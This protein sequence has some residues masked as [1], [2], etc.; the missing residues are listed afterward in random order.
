M[1]IS[2][3]VAAGYQASGAAVLD[4]AVPLGFLNKL[5]SWWALDGD[6]LDAWGPFPL[7]QVSS[8]TGAFTLASTHGSG[9]SG[10]SLKGSYCK[11][12]DAWP[13]WG[14]AANPTSFAIGAFR[15]AD[16][17]GAGNQD[18]V[19]MKAGFNESV[20]LQQFSAGL[21]GRA[22]SDAFG[23]GMYGV[24]ANEST[25]TWALTVLE[26]DVAGEVRYHRNTALSV[27]TNI[28]NATINPISRVQLGSASV[29][30]GNISSMSRMF[31]IKGNMTAPE[32]TYLYNGGAG[33]TI[34]GIIADAS[35]A[36]P[37]CRVVPSNIGGNLMKCSVNG[38]YAA[39]SGDGNAWLNGNLYRSS[40]KYYFTVELTAT[41]V[42]ASASIGV[43]TSDPYSEGYLVQVGPGGSLNGVTA[44]AGGFSTVSATTFPAAVAGGK[45]M[46]A[47]DFAAGKGWYG[48]NGTWIGNPAAGTGHAFS[49]SGTK[50][51]SP[52]SYQ[53]YADAGYQFGFT[54]A[55]VP[56]AAPTGF[57]PWAD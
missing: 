41:P 42:Y 36:P 35:Y 24:S 50:S 22:V 5:V 43:V 31:A 28:G 48:Y 32:M 47:V 38:I 54:A 18:V 19:M 23:P 57:T 34:S 20:N 29:A 40:G 30:N 49:F 1:I 52:F 10:Q 46:V 4:P 25:D 56:Y 12:V 6:R 44:A 17:F 51:V 2:G 33:R 53:N 9:L 27:A 39:P 21:G 14:G 3:V 26:H 8:G 45:Y 16:Y 11:T 15:S 7:S 55:T 13:Q 37:A